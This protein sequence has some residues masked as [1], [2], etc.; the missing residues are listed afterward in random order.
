MPILNNR[1]NGVKMKKN[2]FMAIVNN[3]NGTIN[4]DGSISITHDDF[5]RM[6]FDIDGLNINDVSK[7][8][9][10]IDV[11]NKTSFTINIVKPVKISG[12]NGVKSKNARYHVVTKLL[13]EK[14]ENINDE[15][16]TRNELVT[17]LKSLNKKMYE[18][19]R[20]YDELG[21]ECRKSAWI[22]RDVKNA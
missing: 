9:K 19:I 16:T 13:D 22:E 12:G 11:N 14:T 3:N 2:D 7:N 5:E 8:V 20:I 21:N 18:Y 15:L 6:L 17:W 1:G 10:T 4:N